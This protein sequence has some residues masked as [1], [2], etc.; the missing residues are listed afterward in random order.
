MS[1]ITPVL[2]IATEFAGKYK[3]VFV[4]GTLLSS[5]DTIT[6]TQKVSGIGS[7]VAPIGAVI[8]GS[9]TT[10]LASLQVSVSGLVITIASFKADGTA[11]TTTGTFAVTV[12]GQTD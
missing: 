11:A 9:L 7:L 8:T 4:T 12:L 1:A 6:L 3:P 5:S 10:T 2:S